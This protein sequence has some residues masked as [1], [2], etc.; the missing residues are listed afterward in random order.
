MDQDSNIIG[1]GNFNVTVEAPAVPEPSSLGLFGIG[2]A[3]ITALQRHR[4]K[5]AVSS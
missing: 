5:A 2:L 1:T 3:A 4:R